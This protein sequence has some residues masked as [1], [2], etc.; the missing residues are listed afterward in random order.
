LSNN[1]APIG[2]AIMIS[3]STLTTRNV[4]YQ[5]NVGEIGGAIYGINSNVFNV[6]RSRTTMQRN[7][8]VDD[9][10]AIYMIGGQ[11]S[12]RNTLMS[13]NTAWNSV[14]LCIVVL[15]HEFTDSSCWFM[16]FNVNK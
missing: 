10:G 14:R 5:D 12:L 8:A 4:Q 15:V 13:N 16:S 9:G 3:N 7:H 2:G 1:Q 6:P 11:L